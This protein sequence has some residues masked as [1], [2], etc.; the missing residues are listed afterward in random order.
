MRLVLAG[1]GLGDKIQIRS[2]IPGSMTELS[3]DGPA[4]EFLLEVD[5]TAAPGIYPLAVQTK[6]GL[7]NTWLFSVSEFPETVEVESRARRARRNDSASEAQPIETP[8]VVNGTLTEADR[9]LYEVWLEAGEPIV[10]EVEARRLGSAIDP[11]LAVWAPDG[12]LVARTNDSPGIGQDARVALPAPVEGNYTVEVH[13][14]RFSRQARN[15]YRLVAAPIEFAEEI[16]PLGWKAGEP[17]QVELSGG[18]LS[19]PRKVT[20]KGATAALPGMRG[21]LPMPFLRGLGTETIESRSRKRRRLTEGTVVNG[22]ISQPGE[23]DRYRLSVRPGEEWMIETQ[24]AILG[25]SQLYTLLVLRDQAGEKLGSAGDQPPEELLSNISTRAETFGDPALGLTVP[26]GVSELEISVEDLLGRGG[27]G[28]GYRL[29]ARRQSADFILR[30]D[31][32]HVNV[33]RDGSAAVSVTLDRRGFEGAIRVVAEGLPAGVIAEGGNIPAEF[34][35]MTTQRNSRRG[36]LILNASA[37][38]ESSVAKV[39]FFG[40]GITPDGRIIRRPALT[41][42]IVTPVAGPGQRAL[43][44]PSSTGSV[45]T[46]VA[47]PAPAELKVLSPR[48]LRLIQG[49]ERAIEWAYH[50]RENGVQAISPVQLV[51]APSVANLRILGGA[52]IK[53]GD[54]KGT[55]EMNTTM[56]TPAMRFDLVL[57]A[58]VRHQGVQHTIYS[59]AITVDIVQ[60]YSVGAPEQPV[61]VSAGAGFSIGGS[62]LR[63]PDFDSQ[64]IVEASNLPV[65][66]RCDPQT[67]A[68]TPERYSLDCRAE[69]GVAEGEHLVEITP[70]SILAGRGTEAVPYNIK[71]VEAILVIAAGD[72]MATVEQPSRSQ[73]Q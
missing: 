7:T 32:T 66:V 10:F 48:S 18:T 8:R 22:R 6:A 34:G 51:N 3:A 15:F 62:F 42:R 23:I 61:D 50:A 46:V 17:V 29:V 9:D 73:S 14:A 25:T 11:V 57:Q 56:G 20:V 4:R 59:P 26:A 39:S 43:R 60:G 45:D 53:V 19:K 71:P 65:G 72:T 21:G 24:A 40:E 58:R 68:D 37:D 69:Q 1:N 33:P 44:L 30:L 70:Q 36:R 49:L 5:R 27:R 13:D 12:S 38:A 67:I 35:G 41:S 52:K 16:F 31:D 47:D 28:F 63:E 2:G 55:F 54:S 64:V